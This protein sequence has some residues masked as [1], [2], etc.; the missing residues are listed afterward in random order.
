MTLTRR[1]WLIQPC[2]S[3]SSQKDLAFCT[4]AIMLNIKSE[5]DAIMK[6]NSQQESKIFIT[7]SSVDINNW[8][9]RMK[10]IS[11]NKK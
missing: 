2:S 11:I 5:I 9:G 8:N 4:T 7:K 10:I 1:I 3:D 6:E